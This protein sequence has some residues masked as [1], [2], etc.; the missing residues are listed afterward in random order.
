[1]SLNWHWFFLIRTVFIP[2]TLG[3]IWFT[4]TLVNSL[5]SN[6]V[7]SVKQYDL[8]WF[9]LIQ[10]YSSEFALPSFLIHLNPFYFPFA[11]CWLFASFYLTSITQIHSVIRFNSIWLKLIHFNSTRFALISHHLPCVL[12]QFSLLHPNLLRFS[13]VNFYPA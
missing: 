7:H 11:P 12:S 13:L 2:H 9:F 6:L 3:F 4:L 5:R 10:T 8:I 1:M